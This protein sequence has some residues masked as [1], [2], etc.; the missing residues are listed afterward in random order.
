M[1]GTI[2]DISTLEVISGV[3]PVC[4]QFLQQFCFCHWEMGANRLIIYPTSWAKDEFWQ[5]SLKDET[6]K[7]RF[8]LYILCLQTLQ[9]VSS[10]HLVPTT[11]LEPKKCYWFTP[12]LWNHLKIA[13]KTRVLQLWFVWRSAGAWLMCYC[14]RKE[15]GHL[16]NLGIH[17]K[18]S[19]WTS[20]LKLK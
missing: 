5:G 3:I 12:V 17:L 16:Y 20:N 18:L 1:L 4:N 10:T 2:R 11:T 14:C 19:I 6:I 8:K 9:Q 15:S 7:P 13:T